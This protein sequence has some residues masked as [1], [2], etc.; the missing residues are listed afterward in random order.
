MPTLW[1]IV[2]W[3]FLLALA[4][5]TCVAVVACA[6]DWIARI[7][8]RFCRHTWQIDA[9]SIAGYRM[10]RCSKCN[11]SKILDRYQE[12]AR[13]RAIGIDV[14]DELERRGVRIR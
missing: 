9:S 13:L 12:D 14:A 7:R 6:A 2:K 4:F 11:G 1:F 10:Q 5:S 3:C 8:R